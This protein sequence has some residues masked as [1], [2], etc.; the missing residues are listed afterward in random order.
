MHIK[1]GLKL[2][3]PSK[4]VT[5]SSKLSNAYHVDPYQEIHI[6]S[7][8]LVIMIVIVIRFILYLDKRYS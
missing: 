8:M 4:Y 1:S 7:W 2:F 6:V 3:V 5:N